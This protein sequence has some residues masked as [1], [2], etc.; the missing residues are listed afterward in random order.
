MRLYASIIRDYTILAKLEHY[1]C[2]AN[3]LG[4]AGHL[5]EAENMLKQCP[6]NQMWLHGRLCLALAEFMVIW[7]WQNVLLNMFLN[8]F[9]IIIESKSLS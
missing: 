2:M 4:C 9:T 3:L 1:T 5:Q 7:R 6:V 8:W